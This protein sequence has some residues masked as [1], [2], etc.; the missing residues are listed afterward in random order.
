MLPLRN[1]RLLCLVLGLL[2]SIFLYGCRESVPPA[3]L[4][5][6][7]D[8]SGGADCIDENGKRVYK[9]PSELLNYWITDQAGM[10]RFSAWCYDTSIDV[11]KQALETKSAEIK[12]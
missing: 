6:Q 2:A 4:I 11:T 9:A 3:I 10:A 5:C 12:E 8:G 1:G 7:G